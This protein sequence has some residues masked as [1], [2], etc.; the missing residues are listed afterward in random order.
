M[1]TKYSFKTKKMIEL[2]EEEI[3]QCAEVFSENYGFYSAQSPYKPNDRIRMRVKFYKKR[4][5]KNDFY[6]SYAIFEGR[7]VAH[8]IYLRKTMPNN[9]VMT[10]VVQL[11]VAEA[12]RN[13]GIGGKLLHSIWG[14]SSDAA[15][16]LAT[17]NPFTVKTLEI[18]TFRKVKP[19]EVLKHLEEIKELGNLV[20]FV[21]SY[22]V[23]KNQSLVDSNFFVNVD[24]IEENIDKAFGSDKWML[25]NIEPGH[26]WLAFTFK[27]QEFAE[28]YE[29]HFE[30]FMQFSEIKLKEAYGRM[31]INQPWRKHT[32][33]EVDYIL[34]MCCMKQGDKVLDFGCGTGRHSIELSRRGINV[35]G[36]DFSDNNIKYAKESAK[37]L[38]IV[39]FYVDDCRKIKSDTLV[40]TVIALY[41]VVG[42]FPAV[43]ENSQIIKNAYNNLRDGG[44]F[45]I[46][47]MNMELT[48][49]QAKSNHIGNIKNNLNLLQTLKAS[50]IMQSSGDVFNPDYYVVDDAEGIVYRKEQFIDDGVLSA[51]Y[52]IRDKR[53][54]MPEIKT[55]LE[56][57][58][59]IIEDARFVQAGHWN[60]KLDGIDEHAKEILI[61]ARK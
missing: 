57:N 50:N 58:G 16:G 55:L 3:Q 35:I 28:E 53:Y 25:G 26:E 61:V 4:Y 1:L 22:K 30:E 14:F 42:S 12:H 18:A 11:V 33:G 23:D 40:D 2:N 6:I 45:V 9:H 29:K 47:V 19:V 60:D 52:V 54:T 44:Y 27:D 17:S 36:V 8:A 38:S 48:L 5:V 10:W 31:D 32:K 46:S 13:K 51:E 43:A 37:E 24:E 39:N 49:Y 21:K 20:E 34:E 15:W 41:D 59:F 56:M 7:E